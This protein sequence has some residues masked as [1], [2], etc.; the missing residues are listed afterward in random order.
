ME[1]FCCTPLTNE[2]E[3]AVPLEGEFHAALFVDL[4]AHVAIATGNIELRTRVDGVDLCLAEV[5]VLDGSLTVATFV[6]SLSIHEDD[7]YISYHATVAAIITSKLRFVF[8]W[9]IPFQRYLS[10]FSALPYLAVGGSGLVGNKIL[11][12]DVSTKEFRGNVVGAVD[13][14]CSHVEEFDA[15]AFVGVTTCAVGTFLEDHFEH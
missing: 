14:H 4:V 8:L 13:F 3:E 6:E 12:S 5:E 15:S 2:V 7:F 1:D 11:S 9:G 10:T